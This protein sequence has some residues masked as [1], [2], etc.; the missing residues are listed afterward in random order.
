[1]AKNNVTSSSIK[2]IINDEKVSSTINKNTKEVTLN[3]CEYNL[4]NLKINPQ[5]SNNINNINLRSEQEQYR[6]L[7][8]SLDISKTPLKKIPISI[9]NKLRLNKDA[10]KRQILDCILPFNKL[11]EQQNNNDGSLVT[12]NNCIIWDYNTG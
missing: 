5:L 11:D 12:P 10:L 9:K 3:C 4:P 6:P 2:K 1:M 8:N 7:E